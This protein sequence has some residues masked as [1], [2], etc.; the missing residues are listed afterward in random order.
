MSALSSVVF[1]LVP[2]YF[3]VASFFV[4]FVSSPQNFTI[5]ELP[6]VV[7]IDHSDLSEEPQMK[8]QE[9][10]KVKQ[11]SKKKQ[12]NFTESQQNSQQQPKQQQYIQEMKSQIENSS[13]GIQGTSENAT[14]LRTY[15]NK[16]NN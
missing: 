6:F 9:P 10:I 16:D 1:L 11:K 7:I 3:L 12:W 4:T 13:S 2:V 14:M 15:L 8:G 5:D